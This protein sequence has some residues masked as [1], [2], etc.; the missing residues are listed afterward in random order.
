MIIE[1]VRQLN[2]QFSFGSGDDTKDILW[3][4]VSRVV[5]N[6]VRHVA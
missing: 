3:E 4:I 6:R 5:K 1:G 2:K